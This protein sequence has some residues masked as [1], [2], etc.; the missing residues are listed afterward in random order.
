M[1]CVL[2][3]FYKGVCRINQWAYF[4]T[5]WD[6]DK[7]LDFG[8]ETYSS[9]GYTDEYLT[10]DELPSTFS[11]GDKVLEL[12][13]SNMVSGYLNKDSF[14][15]LRI[16]PPFYGGVFT[17]NGLGISFIS[18]GSS[19]IY[20][21]D[22]HSRDNFGFVSPD[23][24]SVLLKFETVSDT[25]NFIKYFFLEQMNLDSVGYEYQ[26]YSIGVSHDC[27]LELKN[28]LRIEKDKSKKRKIRSEPRTKPSKVPR[29]NLQRVDDHRKNLTP[30]KKTAIKKVDRER[31]NKTREIMTPEKREIIR[32]VDRERKP[33]V[34]RLFSNVKK[35][36]E[37]FKSQISK[38]PLYICVVC[39]RTL[40]H[41]AVQLFYETRYEVSND[42]FYSRVHSFDN[43]EY[44]CKTCHSKLTKNNI[45]SQAVYNDLKIHDLPE[46]FS[47][48]R[49]LEKII[50]AKR[51][52]FKKVTIM[53][54]GQA[55]KMKGAICNVPID[56]ANICNVLP[57][58]MDNNGVVRVALKKKMSFKSNV[59]FQPVRPN[60]IQNILLYLKRQN[61]Y[62]SDIEIQLDAIPTFWVN[63]INNN[64]D[65]DTDSD[66]D[67]DDGSDI[68][69]V[70][71]SSDHR[72]LRGRRCKSS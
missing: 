33:N 42:L 51:I 50:I 56:A 2:F 60:F 58:G 22:P 6:L 65:G 25:E 15:F 44:I 61:P 30:E 40:Y 34:R 64:D 31:K 29:S 46:N 17:A 26:L 13:K 69:F 19:H 8:N 5:T 11:M 16:I 67:G 66:S 47:D 12:Q 7:I 18:D 1:S 49:K 23:G 35:R 10:F 62:Y 36:I 72:R 57:R 38:G 63:T 14:N 55:P 71:K 3:Y 45:P 27:L 28:Y 9:L 39:N 24:K 21:F 32:A 68:D 48:I 59:Y 43:K 70:N 52:L 54:K 4:W 53:S 20:I 41:S 37:T